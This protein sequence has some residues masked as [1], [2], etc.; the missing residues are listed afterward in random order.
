[1]TSAG[2][3]TGI[4][5]NNKIQANPLAGSKMMNT[6]SGMAIPSTQANTTAE[7]NMMNTPGT[8]GN[9]SALSQPQ[10]M[11][12][13]VGGASGNP[14][15]TSGLIQNTASVTRQQSASQ[16]QQKQPQQLTPMQSHMNETSGYGLEIDSMTAP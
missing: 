12:L 14:S 10:L 5:A 6:P 3:V 7:P 9:A 1:M 4:I 16:Y 13:G 15:A 11:P 8:T 2:P